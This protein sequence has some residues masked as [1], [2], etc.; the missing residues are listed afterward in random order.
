MENINES[1]NSIQLQSK[2]PLT[3][4]SVSISVCDRQQNIN[5]CQHQ[6]TA[7]TTTINNDAGAVDEKSAT[8]SSSAAQSPQKRKQ[9]QRSIT[10][11][12]SS[13]RPLNGDDIIAE[14]LINT[15][16]RLKIMD[17]ST[18]NLT[19][20]LNEQKIITKP[21]LPPP[22]LKQNRKLPKKCTNN[23]DNEKIVIDRNHHINN[24]VI[25]QKLTNQ[26][27]QLRLEISE[28]K[29]ALAS[30]KDAVRE[31]RYNFFFV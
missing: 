11:V 30:E 1:T 18:H 31:L 27:E 9:M 4:S 24:N 2:Q 3:H 22:A 17:K 15:N 25:V 10:L 13:H 8:N 12:T 26:T 16:K 21:P 29:Q 14:N 5:E 7:K 23:N 28:L 20:Q 6:P 19:T